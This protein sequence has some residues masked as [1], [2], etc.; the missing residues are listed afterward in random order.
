MS[1]L[2][3][4][5]DALK[6]AS[7]GVWVHSEIGRHLGIGLIADDMPDEVPPVRRVLELHRSRGA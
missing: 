3:Q 7:A 2:S 5:M 6:A 1:L 4:G